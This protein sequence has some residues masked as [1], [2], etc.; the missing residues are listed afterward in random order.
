MFRRPH[1]P[2]VFERLEREANDD[3]RLLDELGPAYFSAEHLMELHSRVREQLVLFKG[4]QRLAMIV[5][6]IGTGWTLMVLMF[7]TIGFSVRTGWAVSTAGDV[8]ADGYSD[9]IIGDWRDSV[10]TS[11]YEGTAFVFHGSAAGI[12]TV[13]ATI[14]Q[15]NLTQCYFGQS[16]STAVC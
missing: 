2:D 8:N 12:V 10:G 3:F 14:L 5:G 7:N 11:F 15:P 1:Q 16:V 4:R 9:V 6:V 13:P